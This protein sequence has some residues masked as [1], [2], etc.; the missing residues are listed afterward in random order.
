MTVLTKPFGDKKAEKLLT[1]KILEPSTS[2]TENGN[3]LLVTRQRKMSKI[4]TVI[5]FLAAVAVLFMGIMGGVAIYQSCARTRINRFHGFCGVPYDSDAVSNQA[6]LYMNSPFR[7]EKT[8]EPA[9]VPLADAQRSPI[10]RSNWINPNFFKEEI[11]LG[12]D[13]DDEDDSFSKID[14]PD[15][16]DGRTGRFYH[17]FKFNQSAIV[18]VEAGR[19]FIMP[20]DRS[21]VELPKNFFDLIIKMQQGEYNID[22]T[23]V[24][25]NMRVVLPA[26]S[27]MSTIAPGIANECEGKRTYMLEKYV[28]GVFKRSVSEIPDSG[29]FAEF[30][31]KHIEEINIENMDAVIAYERQ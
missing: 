16:R 12:F 25:K 14:I 7:D 2:D 13:D 18:D 10:G 4:T 24:K 31:G 8:G 6:M 3:V 20:L 5:L 11:D 26:V 19:C 30:G 9:V 29:K 15:F 17:D 27:D 23:V 1:N 21:T 28:S 22:T